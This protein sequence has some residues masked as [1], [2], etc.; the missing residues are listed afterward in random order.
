MKQLLNNLD[1][2]YCKNKKIYVF[3]NG[4]FY[5]LNL[6]NEIVYDVEDLEIVRIEKPIKYSGITLC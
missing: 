5:P 4:K 1:I 6:K 2:V 3:V